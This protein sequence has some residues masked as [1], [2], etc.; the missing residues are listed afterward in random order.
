MCRLLQVLGLILLLAATSSLAPADAGVAPERVPA[1]G[2]WEAEYVEYRFL[3]E[4]G[5]I[6]VADGVVRGE[7]PVKRLSANA[8]Q[9][10][11]QGIFPCT[12]TS[13][14]RTFRR[15]DE[16]GGHTFLTVFRRF[17]TPSRRVSSPGRGRARPRGRERR[18]GG[19]GT[20]L[21]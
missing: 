18:Q 7:R 4:L 5:Q 19:P 8:R 12:D 13:R 1:N 20:L 3:P 14:A 17:G 21:A 2:E 6:S 10:A 9:L 11:S 15:T 16:M